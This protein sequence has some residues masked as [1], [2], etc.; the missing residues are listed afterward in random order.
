MVQS[1]GVGAALRED[2]GHYS[3]DFMPVAADALVE[4]AE[5]VHRNANANAA[6][7]A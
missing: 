3:S 2:L 4:F 6:V 7:A 1:F 5:S